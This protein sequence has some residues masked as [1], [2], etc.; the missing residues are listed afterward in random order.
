MTAFRH[1]FRKNFEKFKQNNE[2]NKLIKNIKTDIKY[3]YNRK[4]DSKNP[5]SPSKMFSWLHN[6]YHL[7]IQPYIEQNF[8]E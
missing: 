5:K 3:A 8:Y 2:F 7:H 6:E 4:L 1:I